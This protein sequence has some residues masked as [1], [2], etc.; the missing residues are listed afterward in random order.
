MKADRAATWADRVMRYQ[1][2]NGELRYATWDAFIEDFKATF[3]PENEATDALMKL[4]SDHYF[5]R[6]RTVDTYVDEFEDLIALSGY[7]DKLAIVIKFH[8]GLNPAIQDKIAE[9]GADRPDDRNPEAWYAAARR[10]DQNRRANE[11][12]NSSSMCEKSLTRHPCRQTSR[13]PGNHC[14][15]LVTS[16]LDPPPQ[17]CQLQQPLHLPTEI[18]DDHSLLAPLW[19]LMRRNE[20]AI[21]R[22]VAIAVVKSAIAAGTARSHSTSVRCRLMTAKTSSKVS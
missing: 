6:K 18:S 20:M 8:R 5:Q 12:F 22:A 10:F 1:E 13:N 21:S 3:Y 15:P 19:I 9:M 2:R 11:A 14:L 17:P 16:G 7:S 4:E